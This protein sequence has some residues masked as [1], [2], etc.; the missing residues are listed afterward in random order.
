VTRRVIEIVPALDHCGTEQQMALL[1]RGLPREGFDVHVCAL[2]RGGPLETELQRA[3]VP[4]TV[5][6]QRWR[7]DPQAFW[8]LRQYVAQ[9]RPDLIHTWRP[10]AHVYGHAAA[11]A[12]GV[13]T[14]VA[15]RRCVDPRQGTVAAAVDR[16]LAGHCRH[17]IVNSADVGQFY[18]REGLP[19]D[20]VR[21]I[22]CGVP[23][24]PACP[25]TRRQVLAE[26]NLSADSRLIGLV[27]R[28]CVRKRIKDAIWAADLLKVIRDDVHLIVIGDGPHRDR[29]WKFREQVRIRDK[30]HFLGVRGD[31]PLWMPHFDVFWSAAAHGGPSL[32]LLEAMA[33][34]VPVVATDIPATRGLVVDG[35][36]GLLVP[37]GDRATIARHTNNL[38]DNAALAQRL[39]AAGRQRAAAEFGV[40]KMVEQYAEVYCEALG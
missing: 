13:G 36:T 27:G 39:G 26:L 38:L 37:V 3:G 22:P 34:G 24:A 28:L 29:L 20:K 8:R 21:A 12:C 25:V 6:G 19:L 5:I 18:I 40:D 30:V 1:A 15:T 14:L 35:A 11:R 10:L 17:V 9:L 4:V 23:P 33:A 31:V 32:A 7:L 16:Y 2:M